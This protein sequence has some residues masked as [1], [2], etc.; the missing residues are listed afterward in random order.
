MFAA[1][2]AVG[3]ADEAGEAS[4]T[5]SDGLFINSGVC[6]ADGGGTRLEISAAVE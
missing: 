6:A 2:A 5:V 1:V 4:T 3:C